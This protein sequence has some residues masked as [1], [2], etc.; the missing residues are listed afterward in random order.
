MSPPITINTIAN[1]ASISVIKPLP[2]INSL[3]VVRSPNSCWTFTFLR[4]TWRRNEASNTSEDRSQSI[5]KERRV[6]KRPRIHSILAQK[7]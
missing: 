1:G 3:M 2:V 7:T 5:L 4:P 6:N